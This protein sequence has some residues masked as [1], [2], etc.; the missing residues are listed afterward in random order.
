MILC[1]GLHLVDLDLVDGAY[2][3][4]SHRSHHMELRTAAGT[5]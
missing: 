4:D 5:L 1:G 3:E 2:I